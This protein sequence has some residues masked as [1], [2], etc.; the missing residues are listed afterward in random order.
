M[1]LSA[2]DKHSHGRGYG[3]RC[4]TVVAPQLWNGIPDSLK[5]TPTVNALKCHLKSHL[6]QIAYDYKLT[7]QMSVC[8]IHILSVSTAH[9]AV[10]CICTI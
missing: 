3:D 9:R 7:C 2:L 5:C 10:L 6:F 8:N 4:F 1:Q